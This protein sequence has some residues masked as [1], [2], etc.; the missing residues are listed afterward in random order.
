VPAPLRLLATAVAVATLVLSGGA[1]VAD[2]QPLAPH[3]TPI[4]A[5]ADANADLAAAEEVAAQGGPPRV[6]PRR[7]GPA[8]I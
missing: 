3:V 8:S 5:L 2:A 7:V 1:S 6:S 4:S